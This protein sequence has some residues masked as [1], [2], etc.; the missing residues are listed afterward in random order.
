MVDCSP[1]TTEALILIPA[2]FHSRRFPGK[3]LAPLK[4]R[5]MIQRVYG[6][7]VESGHAVTVVTDDGR[8][9]NHLLDLGAKVVRVDDKVAS[10]TER[11]ALAYQRFFLRP[12]CPN[13]RFVVNVQG[14]EPLLAGDLIEEL[15]NFH[16]ASSFDVTTFVRPRL[17]AFEDF[18]NPHVVKALLGEGGECKDF[19]R[20]S[21]TEKS[22][23]KQIE[24]EETRWFQ[25]IGIYCYEISALEWFC[26]WP[27]SLREKRDHLEQLRGLDHGLKYGAVS[28]GDEA[29][30][31][32]VDTPEDLQSVLEIIDG[33]ANIG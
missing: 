12:S 9:E 24:L 20:R 22:S 31:V 28:V 6:N 15:V 10:G 21:K 29:P 2:R 1:M 19:F 25:H 5:S 26:A 17:G 11:I 3:P 32:G 7:M 16:S 18:A 30:L 4:G 23:R 33:K 8:I 14:D 13:Y 27:P